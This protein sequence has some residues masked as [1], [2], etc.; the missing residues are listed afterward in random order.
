MKAN[1]K[2]MSELK[3][4]VIAVIVVWSLIPIEIILFLIFK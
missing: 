1:R 2:P 4:A 3:K